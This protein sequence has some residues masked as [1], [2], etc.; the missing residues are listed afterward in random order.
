MARPVPTTERPRCVVLIGYEAKFKS[1]YQEAIEPG[2]RAAGYQCHSAGL[3]KGSNLIQQDL[4]R[5]L[6]K[7]TVVV[8][9]CT[10]AKPNVL[11]EIGF[12]HGRGK[13]VLLIAEQG[14]DLP[15][16]L[17]AFKVVHYDDDL[18]W[19]SRRIADHIRPEALR[20]WGEQPLFRD[21]ESNQLFLGGLKDNHEPRRWARD[22]RLWMAVAVALIPGVLA[23]ALRRMPASSAHVDAITSVPP[24]TDLSAPAIDHPRQASGEAATEEQPLELAP[25]GLPAPTNTAATP[26]EAQPPTI[27]FHFYEG[28]SGR[29]LRQT[30]LGKAVVAAVARLDIP[31]R[32]RNMG[33]HGEVTSVYDASQL[34][35]SQHP[36]IIFGAKFEREAS[37]V[38]SAVSEALAIDTTHFELRRTPAHDYELIDVLL[39]IERRDNGT[40]CLVGCQ[41]SPST[42]ASCCVP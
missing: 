17:R 23:L 8:A 36:T 25:S 41:Q 16:L 34:C 28:H 21:D 18:A 9:D 32:N 38:T 19:L 26:L 7:A 14:T 31:R 6:R 1:V 35:A 33:C 4:A 30:S 22:K 24:A 13:P 37:T 10:D 29:T 12:A 11:Y 40:V 42:E 27:V 2:V 15:S 39:P 20:E 5:A 3:E